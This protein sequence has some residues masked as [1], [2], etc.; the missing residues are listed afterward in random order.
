MLG[1]QPQNQLKEPPHPG[2]GRP[3]HGEEAILGEYRVAL[4]PSGAP[5]HLEYGRVVMLCP[6]A[7]ECGRED[8][9]T[10]GLVCVTV[11]ASPSQDRQAPVPL[12]PNRH[13]LCALLSPWDGVSLPLPQ[14]CTERHPACSW[15]SGSGAQLCGACVRIDSARLFERMTFRRW[16]DW[17]L[18]WHPRQRGLSTRPQPIGGQAFFNEIAGNVPTRSGPVN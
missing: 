10:L 16:R 8:Q 3:Q 6:P 11:S 5:L 4:R 18:S 17:S 7:A 15:A 1:P 14:N 9:G 13:L 2:L 12:W